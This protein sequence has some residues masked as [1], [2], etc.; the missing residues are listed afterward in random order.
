MSMRWAADA[1]DAPANASAASID[2][3]VIISTIG[4]LSISG[5]IS[6]DVLGQVGG[7]SSFHGQLEVGVAV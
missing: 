2:T 6:G 5:L 4:R 1:D 3:R 7:G